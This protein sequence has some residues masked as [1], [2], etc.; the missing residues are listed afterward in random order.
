MT[1]RTR[2]DEPIAVGCRMR[3][4]VS[5]FPLSILLATAAC[6]RTGIVADDIPTAVRVEVQLLSVGQYNVLSL[7][8]QGT[9][10]SA[11]PDEPEYGDTEADGSMQ[12]SPEAQDPLETF[13]DYGPLRTG[14][15]VF[16]ITIEGSGQPLFTTTCE[17]DIFNKLNIV[18]F[19]EQQ[20]GCSSPVGVVPPPS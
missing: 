6:G 4:V 15:W 18:R 11:P 19:A 9:W 13:P 8:W 14:R 7:Q 5:L 2:I 20:T 12:L 1:G 3:Q 10:L 16:S 17:Q